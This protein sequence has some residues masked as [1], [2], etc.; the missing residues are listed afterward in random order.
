M[1][2]ALV[3]PSAVPFAVGGAEKLWWGLT[4]HVNRYTPHAMEL[5]KLPS[6]ER[7]FWEIVRSYRQFSSLNL[8]H[9]DLVISTKY[10]AWMVAHE[11][12]V[13]YLQ[14]RLRGLYDTYPEHLALRPAEL[15]PV[16]APVWNLL[17]Q[18]ALDRSALP[19]FFEH[20]EA[21]RSNRDVPEE[22]KETLVAFPGPFARAVV[23]ALDRIALSQRAIRRY[24]AISKTVAQREA[25]FPPGA[26]VEVVPHPSDLE[27]FRQEPGE[28]IFTASR[29]DPPK[30]IDLLI[31]AFRRSRTDAALV[32]AGEGPAAD[33]L[34]A[35]A[36]GDPRIRFAGR[37]A[38]DDMVS[39]YAR[40]H[41]VAFIP[42]QE[43]MGLVTLEAM[44]SGKPVLTVSDA[45]GVTEFVRDGVNGRVVAPDAESLARAIDAMM[46][47]R[48]RLLAMGDAARATGAEVSWKRTADALLS[49]ARPAGGSAAAP[50]GDARAPWP[51]TAPQE[52]RTR[53]LVLNTFGVFPPNS[54]GKKRIF[55]LFE[56]LAR[57]ADIT[58]LNLG[59]AGSAPELREFGA[60][61]RE[62]RIPPDERFVAADA[63][64]TRT[65]QR[66]VTDIT[67]LLHAHEIPALES[68]LTELMARSDVLVASHV[69]L[70]PLIARHWRG[71][72]WY[73]AHNV[74]ADMKAD[75]LGVDRVAAPFADA[76]PGAGA[77]EP[78]ASNATAA[79]ARVASAER[80]L[81]R[82]ATRVLAASEHDASRLAD[83]YGREIDSI[84][85]VPN[86][87]SLPED[88]WLD[89]DR[90]A[91]L[92]ASLGF[93][94]RPVALFVGSDHGPNH[95][96][97]DI[98]VAAARERPSWTFVVAGSICD[99]EGLRSVPDRVYPVGLVSQA[100]LTT[101]FRAADVGLNPMLRGSGT[102]LKM[103]DYAA[104]G[105]LV[106]STEI[107]ARGLGFVADTHYLP[108][109]P[110]RLA[111]ALDSLEP[112]LPSP[113]LPMRAAA[114]EL[115]EH[116]FS[117]GT[118]ADRIA[119]ARPD[120]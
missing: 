98:L 53:M 77:A 36:D 61:F 7:N 93:D 55:Y 119:A 39:H 70:A 62:I 14:H 29:L 81:V 32:I 109:P 12:H 15:P 24:Y 92:K 107:G 115:V 85:Y 9:F 113:R 25:Y 1:R 21:F 79:V 26:A 33:A 22:L 3:A 72:L 38:D 88:P 31:R 117:W 80:A 28:F 76:S 102:N 41:F 96:A 43:D 13:V 5:L 75:I 42:F 87:V 20:L 10:P 116:R 19:E 48:P 82:A 114:R 71:E 83:L 52:Q 2:I 100:E 37:L 27:G 103:L 40:A 6:P 89:R 86:G 65:L 11:N 74:E 58:L 67:A 95:E 84:E 49:S 111:Q 30:R 112:E 99:Y 47:D 78:D 97:A 16:L 69:Y 59:T 60:H 120:A 34:R 104:H 56:A 46:A 54:G 63:A 105:A 18:G 94:G 45:G 57:H 101:L 73:D 51:W 108:F 23:H 106:L 35:L 110:D 91:R 50:E 68:V 17:Q 44:K 64:L 8:D 66:S 4:N 90:R 118:I